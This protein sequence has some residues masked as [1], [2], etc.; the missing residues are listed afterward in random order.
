M[1]PECH[2]VWRLLSE[3]GNRP[4]AVFLQC[5]MML[6]MV[7][8]LVVEISRRSRRT[9]ATGLVVLRGMTPKLCIVHVSA[10]YQRW[11]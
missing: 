10:V 2:L 9:D 7:G 11:A 8:R 1:S 3:L 6:D 5:K 4:K